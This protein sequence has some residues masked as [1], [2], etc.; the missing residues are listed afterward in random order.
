MLILLN[1]DCIV[2]SDWLAVLDQALREHPEFGIIGCT[3]LNADGTVNHAGA[4]LH[5]PTTYGQHLTEIGDERDAED[6]GRGRVES[7]GSRRTL[8]L[9][10]EIL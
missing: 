9:Q 6:A 8:H 5:R 4:K 10:C 7:S 3:I 2:H 1:Q